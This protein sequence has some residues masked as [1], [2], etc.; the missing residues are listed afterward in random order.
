MKI[1]CLKNMILIFL[2]QWAN[3]NKRHST[4]YLPL[5]VFNKRLCISENY[6]GYGVLQTPKLK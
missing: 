3:N 2:L 1:L 4:K 5:F 6:A